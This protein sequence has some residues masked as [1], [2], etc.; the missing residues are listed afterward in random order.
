MNLLFIPVVMSVIANS[1]K[2]DMNRDTSLSSHTF[3]IGSSFNSIVIQNEMD[4]Y[5]SE[6][7][8]NAIIVKNEETADLIKFKVKDG[9]LIIKS[10]GSFIG[11]KSPNVI[12]MVKNLS[13]ISI[14]GD[15][16]VRT[17]GELSNCSLKLYIY[18]DGSIYADTKA[19]EVNTLI[20]GLGKIEVKGNFKNVTVNKDAWGDMVTTYK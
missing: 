19:T 17:I 18:G 7:N 4:V 16:E 2:Q 3:H 14:M 6:G 10:R 11:R 15:S 8:E 1:P 5:I 20:K 13:D 9:V 12:I